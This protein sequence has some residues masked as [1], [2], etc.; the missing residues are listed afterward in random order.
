MAGLFAVIFVYTTELYPTVI[1][2][3]CVCMCVVLCVCVYVCV[4]VCGMCVCLLQCMCVLYVCVCSMCVCVCVCVHG[5]EFSGYSWISG[6][7]YFS[8][9][10]EN[11]I[12]MYF[13]C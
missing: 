7:R 6:I 1:R 11:Y 8:E 3:V 5:W 4:C 9:S 12:E 13:K 2:C 10:N